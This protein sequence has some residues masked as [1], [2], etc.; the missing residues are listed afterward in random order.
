MLSD[1]VIVVVVVAIC[2]CFCCFFCI[3]FTLSLKSCFSVQNPHIIISRPVYSILGVTLTVWNVIQTR[4]TTFQFQIDFAELS[5][6]FLP[7][8][9]LHNPPLC[10][11]H[12]D[13][14]KS[15]ASYRFGDWGGHKDV[16]SINN[17]AIK[18]EEE[19]G[20]GEGGSGEGGCSVR[21]NGFPNSKCDQKRELNKNGSESS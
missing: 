15:R 17:T 7:R 5:A 20:W 18:L 19:V 4:D 16:C 21:L 13:V 3:C 11:V 14:T 10:S 12:D 2:C 8:A 9:I 6:V 1:F